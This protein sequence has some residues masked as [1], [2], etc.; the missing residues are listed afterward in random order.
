VIRRRRLPALLVALAIAAAACAGEE[1]AA[2]KPSTTARSTTTTTVREIVVQDTFPPTSSTLPPKP[3]VRKVTRIIP[4]LPADDPAP[5]GSPND[6]KLLG[7]QHYAVDGW[8]TFARGNKPQFRGDFAASDPALV[9]E[10]ERYLMYHTCVSQGEGPPEIDNGY[11]A[12][13]CVASSTDGMTWQLVDTGDLRT[14]G[15]VLAGRSGKWDENLEATYVLRTKDAFLL[16]YGGYT[17]EPGEPPH[18]QQKGYPASMGLARSTDGVHFQRVQ[19]APIFEGTTGGPDWDAVYSPTITE[20][21]GTYYMAYAGHCYTACAPI[22]VRVLGATSTDGIT[23]EKRTEPVLIGRPSDPPWMSEGAAEPGYL[24]GDDGYWYLFFT[25]LGINDSRAL[26]VLRGKT[27]FGPWEGNPVLVL[28]AR[29]GT[30]EHQV[31]A[32]DLRLEG[33]RVRMWYLAF[34]PKSVFTIGYAE[35]HW[36]LK[37]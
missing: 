21:D 4:A 28:D 32:P 30:Y 5:S 6:F 8:A 19:D 27:P 31:L 14:R 9:K 13:I 1:A 15:R 36:P 20:K 10:G 37:R 16:Y 34:D 7:D 2:P 23:W 26:G 22:G 17:D 24:E 35:A 25:C 3:A 12:A 33:D 18:L 11:R 29:P